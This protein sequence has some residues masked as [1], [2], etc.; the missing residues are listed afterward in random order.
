MFDKYIYNFLYFVNHWSTKLTSWSWCKLYS[1][2]RK[3]YGLQK[4]KV[5]N[6]MVDQDH[7]LIYIKKT[8]IKYLVK[9]KTTSELLMEGYEKKKRK[10]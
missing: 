8:L 7:L 9:R 6:G 10:N 3:G 4:K 5:D 1:D 2:R